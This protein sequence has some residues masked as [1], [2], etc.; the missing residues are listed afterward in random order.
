MAELA[1]KQDLHESKVAESEKWIQKAV[2]PAHKGNL[3]KALHVA[4]GETIPKAK[5]A[6]A[7]HSKN[8]KLRHMA[9]FAKNVANEGGMDKGILDPD[10]TEQ[11]GADEYRFNNN[12]EEETM[13][14]AG[15]TPKQRKFAKLAPPTDKITFADKIA[16]AKKE[17]DEMLGDVAAE[18]MKAAVGKGKHTVTDKAM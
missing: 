4:Q 12:D 1:N 10:S 17:V 14:E 2:N 16:G 13:G 3:H 11:F 7:T 8:P 18:A 15:M 9:Q 6:K 5:I